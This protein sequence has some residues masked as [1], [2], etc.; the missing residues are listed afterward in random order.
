MRILT[1]FILFP[2]L[3]I[4][5]VFAVG[6]RGEMIFDFYPLPL[7]LA[8]PVYAGVFITV[9]LG[10]IAG[11][12]VCW[13]SQGKW[14]RLARQRKR[15]IAELERDLIAT[16]TEETKKTPSDKARSTVP[17]VREALEILPVIPVTA[18]PTE[19]TPGTTPTSSPG[20][21]AA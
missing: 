19:A 7:T 20:K 18:P 4:A 12:I 13:L 21:P 8:L 11:S 17:I 6:N 16:Q 3:V 2:L 15:R 5:V 9:F 10:F 14:R 1:W